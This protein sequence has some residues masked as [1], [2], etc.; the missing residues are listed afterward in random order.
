MA[1]P[2][3]PKA[4]QVPLA[5]R[6]Y[7]GCTVLTGYVLLNPLPIPIWLARRIGTSYLTQTLSPHGP[8]SRLHMQPY[9][10]MDLGN[11]FW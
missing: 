10:H 4:T 8:G 6:A 2:S 5:P 1:C 11:P 3:T 9:A 7:T